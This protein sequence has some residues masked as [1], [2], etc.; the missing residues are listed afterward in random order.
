[1]YASQAFPEPMALREYRPTV[2][3]TP[4]IV[5]RARPGPTKPLI[6]A[7]TK[8]HRASVNTTPLLQQTTPPQNPGLILRTAPISVP[9]KCAP[10]RVLWRARRP[11]ATPQSLPRH[12]AAAAA[13]GG[14]LGSPQR[15]RG[16]NSG[17]LRRFRTARELTPARSLSVSAPSRICPALPSNTGFL[18]RHFHKLTEWSRRTGAP[19]G[20]TWVPYSFRHLESKRTILQ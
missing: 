2:A 4:A 5:S 6:R 8:K 15:R 19:C 7:I 10:R 12:P 16:K 3:T 14:K 11:I 9:V 17:F 13:A 18:R 20:C 1:M